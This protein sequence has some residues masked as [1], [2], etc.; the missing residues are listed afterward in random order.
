ME[1]IWKDIIGYEGKYQVSN[2]GEV[3]SLSRIVDRGNLPNRIQKERTMKKSV[4]IAGYYVVNLTKDAKQKVHTV[5]S[6]VALCFIGDREGKDTNHIDSNKLNNCLHNLEYVSRREN[7]CHGKSRK[8]SFPGISFIT[9]TKKWRAN[10]VFN[11]V[12]KEL[13][14]FEKQEEAIKQVMDFYKQHN[15][16]NKY[17]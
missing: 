15:I 16:S 13:G 1:E 5:H 11:G 4:N 12:V 7:T 6:L 3:K 10:P 8:H 2:K 14:R 9:K 17:I